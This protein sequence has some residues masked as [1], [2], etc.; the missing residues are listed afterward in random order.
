MKKLLCLML[1]GYLIVPAVKM[2]AADQETIPNQ[3][4]SAPILGNIIPQEVEEYWASKT[5][6]KLEFNAEAA[7]AAIDWSANDS[8]VKNQGSCGS[9][10]AFS[11]VALIENLSHQSDLSEQVVVSCTSYEDGIPNDCSGGWHGHALQYVYNYG[12]PTE[13]D[14]AYTSSNGDCSSKNPNPAYVVKVRQFDK[15]GRWGLANQYTVNNL[16]VLLQSGPVV[17]HMDVPADN[18]FSGYPG[19]TGGIYNY[20]GGTIPAGRG[21]SVLVVG[22]DDAQQCFKVKNSW[23]ASWG[24]NGYF[25]ISYDDVTDDVHFGGYACTAY[26]AYF[27]GDYNTTPTIA[28]VTAGSIESNAAISGGNISNDGGAAVTARGVCWSTSINPTISSNKTRDGSGTGEF[29]STI[30]GLTPSTVYYVRAYATNSLGTSYG[31]NVMFTTLAN[32]PVVFTT[33]TST[34]TQTSAAS[35]GTVIDDG[36]SAVIARGVCWST[37]SEPTINDSKTTDGSGTGQYISDITGLVPGTTYYVRAWAT[38]ESGTGYGNEVS[39]NTQSTTPT[40]ATA[41][42]GSITGTSASCGGNVTNDGGAAVTLRG[43]CWSTSQTPTISDNKTEDGIGEG[44]YA[45]QLVGLRVGTRYYVR[46]YASNAYGTSYGNTV[47]F[48]TISTDGSVAYVSPSGDDTNG[49]GSKTAPYGTIQTAINMAADGDMILVEPGVY[50][51]NLDFNG[52]NLIVSSLYGPKYTII[53]G[54]NT[55]AANER[56]SVVIFDKGE[57]ENAVLNGFTLINGKGTLFSNMRW[58]GGVFCNNSSSP[59][60]KNLVITN[61][62]VTHWG[63][64]I[65][66]IRG[67][68]PVMSNLTIANNTG[69]GCGGIAISAQAFSNTTIAL[70]PA[71]VNSIVWDNSAPNISITGGGSITVAHSDVKGGYIGDQNSDIDP[72]FV[73]QRNMNYQLQANSP[74]IDKGVAL[75]ISNGDTLVNLADDEYNGDAPDMG[76]F[77]S[78]MTDWI[79]HVQASIADFTDNENYLGAALGATNGFDKTFDEAEPPAAPGQGIALYFPHPEWKNQLG[80]NF[81]KDIRPV[82]NLTDT[83]QVWEF[84]VIS[85]DTGKTTL[86]FIKHDFPSVDAVLQNIETGAVTALDDTTTYTFTAAAQTVHVFRICVGD[87]TSPRLTLGASCSG[88]RVLRAGA[89]HMLD[90]TLANIDGIDSVTIAFSPDDGATFTE[91]TSFAD[92]AV[93]GTSEHHSSYDWTVPDSALIYGGKIK[94]SVKNYAGNKVE[95]I[96]DHAFAIV[97][98]KLSETLEPGWHLWGA[99]I[100]AKSENMDDNIGDNL[101][102]YWVTYGYQDNGYAQNK[103]LGLANGYWL[104]MT[105]EA[106]L[107]L[108]GSAI[109]TNYTRELSYGWDLIS[110]PLI[111]DITVD[112]LGFT[113]DDTTKKYAD[114]VA[115]KWINV[116]YDYSGTGYVGSITTLSPWHGYWIAVSKP[117]ISITFPIHRN[118]TVPLA[119]GALDNQGWRIAFEASTDKAQDATTIIGTDPLASDGFDNELDKLKPPLPPNPNYVSLS[120]L[121]PEWAHPLGENF[122]HDIRSEITGAEAK[123]WSCTLESSESAVRLQWDISSVPMEYDV[124]II[125]GDDSAATL[126]LRD[127]PDAYMPGTSSFTVKVVRSLAP[128]SV[129]RQLAIP[130]EFAMQQNYPN[131]FNPST[132]IY[133]Q[134]PGSNHVRMDVFNVLGQHTRTLINADQPAGY[135]Q[136]HWDG[137]NDAGIIVAGGV[138]MYRIQAGSFCETKKMLF[139][140]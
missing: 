11:T 15:Y 42:A 54:S 74:C 123:Q 21:H 96:S 23:G 119:K 125:V 67:S 61:N 8:P 49:D 138:Y 139:L 83:M 69:A 97:G 84:H 73:N 37:R 88:P 130:T 66:C 95:R 76:A 79:I 71:L 31:Q 44:E 82:I 80:D 118:H 48:K 45:S 107:D 104:G 111:L 113:K 10:W 28:T 112:S 63:G 120:I 2:L 13:S 134:L 40:V 16:K 32:P 89:K 109:D 135:Y 70:K 101:S 127:M 64:G 51:E 62:S 50:V 5:A 114:A 78:S 77:E 20:N 102:D 108:T 140:R 68:S 3:P 14:Y 133:Y 6:V 53:D 100:R 17:V 72:K 87:T 92:V 22:Y 29:A 55:N 128:T 9:C 105:E 52:K 98:E 90:W 26:T 91:V 24:E 7:A 132:L 25:R 58:G 60:L 41:I 56:S 36:G 33:V 106:T 19:Y 129:D 126:N 34:I 121:H 27:E 30:T 65:A 43:V 81:A 99:P 93:S 4:S 47:T 115:A 137:R 39:F 122:A 136:L 35:G 46:A 103:I 38:N 75:Y 12:I 131:P 110:N 116:L 85:T 57:T 124:L 1:I 59:T 86:T 94:V 18:T 117:G